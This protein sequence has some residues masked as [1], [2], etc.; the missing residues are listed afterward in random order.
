MVSYLSIIK[1]EVLKFVLLLS[2][3]NLFYSSSMRAE[4][5]FPFNSLI[6]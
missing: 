6:P 2:V 3:S 1:E 4:S 5:Q